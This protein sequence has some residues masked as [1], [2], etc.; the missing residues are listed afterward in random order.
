MQTRNIHQ[1][2][3]IDAPVSKVYGAL[4]SPT[5]MARITGAR[6]VISTKPG[7]RFSAW[8]DDI[9][10][11]T[12]RAERNARLVQAWH[13]DDWPTGHYS[14]ADFQLR[15][16]GRG[17]RLSFHQYGVPATHAGRIA[18]GWKLF[19]WEPLKAALAA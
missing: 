11:F 18:L 6:Y 8:D 3:L 17:T 19:Y 2:I 5:R 7:S 1:S 10:G 13:G 15:K 16:A 9:N 4:T 14:I 12:L